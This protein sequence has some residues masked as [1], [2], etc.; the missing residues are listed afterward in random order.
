MR[1][2]MVL[3][4]VLLGA[5]VC[6]CEPRP[7]EVRLIPR[8]DLFGN[9]ERVASHVSPDGKWISWL[10]PVNGVMNL[11]LAPIGQIEAARPITNETSRGIS[12]S[13][14]YVGL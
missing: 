1:I 11:W 3:C 6:A 14:G 10:A 8:A 7:D 5:S 13:P 4:A 2:S 12:I 9:P